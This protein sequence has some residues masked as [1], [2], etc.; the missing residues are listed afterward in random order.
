MQGEKKYPS[1]QQKLLLVQLVEADPELR[2]GKFSSNFSKKEAERRWQAIAQQL[3]AV[4]GAKKSWDGWR[5]S[6]Q[7]KK[8]KTKNKVAT[9]RRQS[10]LTGGGPPPEQLTEEDQLVLGT[11]SS[12]AVVG[13]IDS[14]ESIVEFIDLATPGTSEVSMCM[15]PGETSGS[16]DVLQCE[17]IPGPSQSIMGA[18]APRGISGSR[19]LIQCD[20][21]P[22]TS[23]SSVGAAALRGT[24]G[25]RG[26]QKKK[27]NAARRQQASIDVA[28]KISA[29]ME[30][31]NEIKQKF[32]TDFLKL[33]AQQ[34][35]AL[36]SIARSMH[37]RSSPYI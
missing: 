2:G 6:W 37:V 4:A 9:I 20:N 32:Y 19:D 29:A 23:Q 35:E 33:M 27:T 3:N 10:M 22:G 26:K 36:A 21:R 18:A 12:A 5:K 28:D 31:K 24:S 15:A 30:K 34:T 8:S 13:H 16:Q 11:F 1:A 7:D 25:A 17:N 14:N